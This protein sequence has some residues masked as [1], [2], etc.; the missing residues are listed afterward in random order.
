MNAKK[1]RSYADGAID[2][3]EMWST[4]DSYQSERDRIKKN[5]FCMFHGFFL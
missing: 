2:F 3:A 5:Y 1:T 4:T